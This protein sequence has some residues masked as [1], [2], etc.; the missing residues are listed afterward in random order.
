MG[1]K[2]TRNWLDSYITTTK[3]NEELADIM[4]TAGLEVDASY[5][6]AHGFS[7]VVVGKIVEAKKHPDA[8]KLSVCQVD[9]GADRN[10]NIVCG[11][12]TVKPGLIVATA[13]IGAK[14]PGITIKKTKLRGVESEGMLCA[15]GELG[16]E[17]LYTK[18][19]IMHLDEGLVLGADL[20]DALNLNDHV[21]EIE[22]TPDRGDCLSAYGVARD[23][24]AIT[25]EKLQ[26]RKAKSPH[27]QES[28]IKV[29]I[30]AS[31]DCTCYYGRYIK[32][33]DVNSTKHF[34]GDDLLNKISFGSI[35]RVVDIA[36]FAMLDKG[37]PFHVFDADKISGNIT[38]R[39]S[40]EGEVANL[41][42]DKTVA[43]KENTLV[44]ADDEKILA[45]AGVMGCKESK[46]SELTKN[47]F[48]EAAHFTPL[49]TA[50]SCRDYRLASDSA[51]RFERGVDAQE[52][53]QRLVELCDH[54]VSVVGGEI[55]GGVAAGSLKEKEAILLRPERLKRLLGID[56]DAN[57][58]TNISAKVE[59]A[60]GGFQVT[61]PS[62]RFDLVE[63]VD[64]I[65]ELMRLHGFDNIPQ[66]PLQ[67]TMAP[68]RIKNLTRCLTREIT[69]Y[70]TN[71][72][73]NEALCYSM[74]SE[75]E[76]EFFPAG[77][78][79]K[80]KNPISNN[81]A[82]MRMSLLPGLVKAMSFNTRRQKDNI[83]FFEIGQCFERSGDSCTNIAGILAG[84]MQEENWRSG[85][86]KLDFYDVKAICEQLCRI[87]GLS[88]RYEKAVIK[89]MHHGKSARIMEGDTQVGVIGVI[90]PMLAKSNDLCQ[91]TV[92]FEIT[93]PQSL[94]RALKY[95]EHSKYPSIKRDLSLMIDSSVSFEQVCDIIS[96]LKIKV[97][98]RVKLSDIYYPRKDDKNTKSLCISLTF[99]HQKRT[100]LEE[101]IITFV[102][103]IVH[104]L[105]ENN[106]NIRS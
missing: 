52:T 43:L 39:Y 79:L 21:F 93:L 103:K 63:E 7:K 35:D 12:S 40:I 104:Q 38:V 58:L 14:L 33:I 51:Y 24:A 45:I 44:V 23:I 15:A 28:H 84:K 5:D 16:L 85:K 46:V 31:E 106:I 76:S 75:E 47:I 20:A 59:K 49:S 6:L 25:G 96:S 94:K 102:T 19:G 41:L 13:T 36:N 32:N 62:W 83:K 56:I 89:G 11:C 60:A 72:G 65:E 74:I 64:L 101:D 77:D 98:Q 18:K 91:S 2:V 70:L 66:L 4:T 3:T 73:M 54:I 67:Y 55:Q 90:D 27:P 1:V 95:E 69:S 22:M 100:L 50:K 68:S 34:Y 26:D 8:D 37:Q 87:M 78:L 48:V 9:V 17:E 97:L 88:V 42:N 53:E 80:L 82:V 81:M 86:Q 71:I 105:A 99:Q 57:L 92:L 10:L 61:P 30:H 29:T